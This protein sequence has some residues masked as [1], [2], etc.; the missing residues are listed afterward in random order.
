M[1]IGG[2]GVMMT[3]RWGIIGSGDVTEVKSGPGFQKADRSALTAVMRR[4]GALAEDYARRH[5]VPKWY[6][7]AEALIHD[8]DVDAVYI[9]T[10]P[11]HH[12]NYTLRCAMAGKPMYVE[13]PMAM[14]EAECAAMLRACEDA[15]V[16]LFVAYYRRMLTRFIQIKQWVESGAIGDVRFVHVV[17]YSKPT[18]DELVG[19][20]SWR[21]QSGISGGGKFLD[22]GSHTLD[23]LDY[24]LGPIESA[25]GTASNQA[26]LY[27]TDDIV[28]AQ[29]TFASGIHGTGIWCFS[30]VEHYEMNEIVGTRGKVRF[31]TF[32]SEP[33]LLTNNSGQTRPYRF[34]QPQHIQ[35]P[36]IQSIVDELTGCGV[37]PSTGISAA[38]TSRVMD[39]IRGSGGAAF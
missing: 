34:E 20:G 4:N 21:V 12:M 23:I 13:K 8:Q 7:D 5:Q 29:F 3:I 33:V 36:L 32:G 17:H 37:C 16:P 2:F 14:N 24:I 11:A 18:P 25:V 22:V 10:P 39:Q 38:R 6:D 15:K 27:D 26:G 35:Q 19:K 31:S 9:A 1:K 30:A 28:S